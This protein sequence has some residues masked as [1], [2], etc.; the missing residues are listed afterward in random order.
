V[1][2]NRHLEYK[3]HQHTAVINVQTLCSTRWHSMRIY[4]Q[5]FT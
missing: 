2:E 3:I 1:T 5:W 4:T